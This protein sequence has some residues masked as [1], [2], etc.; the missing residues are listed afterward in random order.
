MTEP[1]SFPICSQCGYAH[2]VVKTGEKCPLAKEVAPSGHVIEY[3]DFF[4]SLKDI[5]TSQIQMKNI[6]DTKKFL[7]NILVNITKISEGYK[8]I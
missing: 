6:K 7:G 1:M 5:L 4:K 8:E 3:A 2:P